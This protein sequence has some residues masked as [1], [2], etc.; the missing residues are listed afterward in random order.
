MVATGQV[1]R[2]TKET[3]CVKPLP[4]SRTSAKWRRS[5]P[6]LPGFPAASLHRPLSLRG[7]GGLPGGTPGVREPCPASAAGFI[8]TRPRDNEARRGG[9]RPQGARARPCGS[10]PA[11]RSRLPQPLL[12]APLL[13]LRRP[14]GVSEQPHPEEKAFRPA[15]AQPPPQIR[16]KEVGG[17]GGAL[18]SRDAHRNLGSSVVRGAG[19]EPRKRLERS[20]FGSRRGGPGREQEVRTPVRPSRTQIALPTLPFLLRVESPGPATVCTPPASPEGPHPNGETEAQDMLESEPSLTR[21]SCN[22]PFPFL[23]PVLTAFYTP[24]TGRQCGPSALQSGWRLS[25][26]RGGNSQCRKG[27]SPSASWGRSPRPP[28]RPPP[29]RNPEQA[30]PAQQVHSPWAPRAAAAAAC[31]APGACG[32]FQT[33][34]RGSPGSQARLKGPSPIR[35]WA[36]VPTILSVKTGIEGGGAAVPAGGGLTGRPGLWQRAARQALGLCEPRGPSARG[37]AGPQA[38]SLPTARPQ[39]FRAA[40]GFHESHLKRSRSGGG[41]R[42]LRW[43]TSRRRATGAPGAAGRTG[44]RRRIS[45]HAASGARAGAVLPGQGLPGGGGGGGGG[46]TG[47]PGPQDEPSGRLLGG[48]RGAGALPVPPHGPKAPSGPLRPQ[49]PERRAAPRPCPCEAPSSSWSEAR[50]NN[51]GRPR[52]GPEASARAPGSGLLAGRTRGPTGDPGPPRN[53]GP[54]EQQTV[55]LKLGPDPAPR[56]ISALAPEPPPRCHRPSAWP[57]PLPGDPAGLSSPAQPW[58]LTRSPQAVRFPGRQVLPAPPRRRG[59]LS[60]RGGSAPGPRGPHTRRARRAGRGEPSARAEGGAVPGAGPRP[61]HL[62]RRRRRV[63]RGGDGAG[64]A[65]RSWLRGSRVASLQ[66]AC[67]PRTPGKHRVPKPTSDLE[68]LEATQG[69]EDLQ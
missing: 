32:G 67:P 45:R 10:C 13:P 64:S 1:V 18:A 21:G 20:G 59:A 36:Q 48:G 52:G 61:A 5:L 19:T 35:P 12:H 25:G 39:A 9:L 63:G 17:K 27:R 53:Q 58:D 8:L 34:D 47:G 68:S 49:H 22:G 15:P 24:I 26:G 51:A 69:F 14:E 33:L 31:D 3:I 16:W 40:R 46:A 41:R 23:A 42:L 44:P 54:A 37:D 57:V 50:V 11:A 7:L 62:G 2:T 28:A 30:S 66:L 43:R 29:D 60:P 65:G 55:R 4:W 56:S 6:D 38:A